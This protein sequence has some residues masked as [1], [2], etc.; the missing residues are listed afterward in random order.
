MIGYWIQRHDYSADDVSESS[1]EQTIKAFNDFDWALELSQ[2]KENVEGKDCPPG[3]G[4]NNGKPLNEER[5]FL[6]HICPIDK[7]KIFFNFHYQKPSSIFGISTGTSA[8]IHHV[9]GYPK[10]EVSN[11][12]KQFYA[13]KYDQLIAIK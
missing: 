5:G 9:T 4:I 13:G 12:I 11:L 7:H 10:S 6:L 2:F 8:E 1:L 3:I